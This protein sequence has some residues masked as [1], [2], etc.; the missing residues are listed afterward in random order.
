MSVAI[1]A[2]IPMPR[3]TYRGKACLRF[4]PASRDSHYLVQAL[5]KADP[6]TMTVACFRLYLSIVALSLANDSD[7]HPTVVTPSPLTVS[8]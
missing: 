1:T 2:E 7:L 5:G 8:L 4:D 6:E 3:A